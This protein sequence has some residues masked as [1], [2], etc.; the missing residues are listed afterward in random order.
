M[1][2]PSWVDDA[3]WFVRWDVVYFVG[4]VGRDIAY[5]VLRLLSRKSRYFVVIAGR[6]YAN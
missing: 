6:D 4:L 1:L 3:A 5:L 2:G